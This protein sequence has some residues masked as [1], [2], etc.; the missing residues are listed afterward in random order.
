MLESIFD[1]LI[2]T[3]QKLIV[4][5]GTIFFKSQLRCVDQID[6]S[7][8]DYL[9]FLGRLRRFFLYIWWIII[10]VIFMVFCAISAVSFSV[11]THISEHH[12][13]KR[14][15]SFRVDLSIETTSAKLLSLKQ[16]KISPIIIHYYFYIHWHFRNDIE[17]YVND[18]QIHKRSS[19]FLFT[20]FVRT[21]F[22]KMFQQA[23]PKKQKLVK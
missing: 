3:W 1:D 22:H 17:N 18:K 8:W 23:K 15:L 12:W 20:L 6:T 13:M 16:C 10:W 4:H 14:W 9:S 19:V 2:S 5:F 21:I 7:F 11:I